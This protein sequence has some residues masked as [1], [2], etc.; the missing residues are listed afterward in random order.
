M[1]IVM[2]INEFLWISRNCS[3]HT[4]VIT[5]NEIEI[6]YWAQVSNKTATFTN[7]RWKQTGM[8]NYREQ[9]YGISLFI[10]VSSHLNQVPKGAS[11][12]FAFATMGVIWTNVTNYFVSKRE[13]YWYWDILSIVPEYIKWS[14][15]YKQ[16]TY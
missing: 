6:Q 5:V 10:H 7:L 11:G 16:I 3:L 8:C 4:S 2:I 12:T 15:L 13:I 9:K 14:R 1:M